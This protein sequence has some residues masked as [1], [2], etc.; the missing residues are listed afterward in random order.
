MR[1]AESAVEEMSGVES[2]AVVRDQGYR[3]YSGVVDQWVYESLA[4]PWPERAK[5]GIKP[6]ELACAG[7]EQGCRRDSPLG[8]QT[9]LDPDMDFN[10]LFP[11][12]LKTAE[13][14]A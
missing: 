4:C 12:I 9:C 6:G 14:G 1:A 8:F 13:G 7:C 10:E 11:C 2:E 5:W 3:P